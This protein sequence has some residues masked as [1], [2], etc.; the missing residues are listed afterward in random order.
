ME[1]KIAITQKDGTKVKI[2]KSG[3]VESAENKKN[4]GN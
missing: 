3:E 4:T 2:K 1:I